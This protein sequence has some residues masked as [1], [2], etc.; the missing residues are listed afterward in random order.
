MQASVYP[1]PLWFRGGAYSLGGE[2]VGEPI[3]YICK[4]FVAV[5]YNRYEYKETRISKEDRAFSCRSIE[6]LTPLHYYIG[7]VCYIRK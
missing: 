1:P 7:E 4:Y 5:Q 6:L 3:R 2:G